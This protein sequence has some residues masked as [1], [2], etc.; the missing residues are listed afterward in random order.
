MARRKITQVPMSFRPYTGAMQFDNDW[1][2][3]F[4]RGDECGEYHQAIGLVRRAFRQ[5]AAT[6]NLP[7]K[8]DAQLLRALASLQELSQLLR[9]CRV[10]PGYLPPKRPI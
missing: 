9:S 7:G 10:G 3:V 6:G 1:P 2:G 5:R 8:G 4:L